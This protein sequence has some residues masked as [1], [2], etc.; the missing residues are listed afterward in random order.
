MGVDV[1]GGEEIASSPES[2][3]PAPGRGTSVEEL[4]PECFRSIIRSVPCPALFQVSRSLYTRKSTRNSSTR[5]VTLAFSRVQFKAVG[6]N[7]LD[8]SSIAMM[9]YTGNLRETSYSAAMFR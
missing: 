5:I 2:C 4:T 9:Y 1:I 6:C 7:S 3:M 8:D